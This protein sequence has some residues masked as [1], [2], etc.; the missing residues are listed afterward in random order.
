[1]S[2]YIFD[3][4]AA[5]DAVEFFSHLHHSFCFLRSYSTRD[6]RICRIGVG[7]LA[8]PRLPI[9]TQKPFKKSARG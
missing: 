3:E 5:D 4:N 9:A 2:E 8:G 1:M 7:V 6:P